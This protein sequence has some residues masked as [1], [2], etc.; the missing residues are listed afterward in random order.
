MRIL[1]AVLAIGV[2]LEAQNLEISLGRSQTT[3]DRTD[4]VNVNLAYY[5]LSMAYEK[6]WSLPHLS[7]EFRTENGLSRDDADVGGGLSFYTATGIDG[8]SEQSSYSAYYLLNKYASYDNT[9]DN[10]SVQLDIGREIGISDHTFLKLRTDGTWHDYLTLTELSGFEAEPSLALSLSSERGLSLRSVVGGG[11]RSYGDK[12]K[13]STR[14]TGQLQGGMRLNEK[15]GLSLILDGAMDMTANNNLTAFSTDADR[16]NDPYR[17]N[18]TGSALQY[19]YRG[20]ESSFYLKLAAEKRDYSSID[21]LDWVVKSEGEFSYESIVLI[22]TVSNTN[23]STVDY[24]NTG[25]D[26]SV[27]YRR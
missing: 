10:Q 24:S 16:I 20:E 5:T 14:M 12:S 27:G 19:R 4:S 11:V 2:L 18:R 6:A 21:R 22:A 3:Y 25:F 17:Y 7:G 23:S 9:L 26:L 1:I 13:L 8:R 15:S